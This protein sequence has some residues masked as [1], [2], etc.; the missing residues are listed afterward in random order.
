[1]YVN[2]CSDFIFVILICILETV[3]QMCINVL[4][5][6]YFIRKVFIS[7]PVCSYYRKVIALFHKKSKTILTTRFFTCSFYF[8]LKWFHLSQNVTVRQ[9][10]TGRSKEKTLAIMYFCS[11][12]L[13]LCG[14]VTLSVF[15]RCVDSVPYLIFLVSVYSRPCFHLECVGLFYV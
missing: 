6:V 7:F 5:P 10:E 3:L 12:S 11:A 13:Y 4:V 8:L 1:M 15:C 14:V 2:G 9:C